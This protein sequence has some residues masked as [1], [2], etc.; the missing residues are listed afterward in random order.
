MEETFG[1]EDSAKSKYKGV[2]KRG[3]TW[4]AGAVGQKGRRVFLGRFTD[5]VMAA[6]AVDYFSAR[7]RPGKKLNQHVHGE[8]QRLF[9]RLEREGRIQELEPS[10]GLVAAKELRGDEGPPLKAPGK[11]GRPPKARKEDDEGVKRVGDNAD[12]LEPLIEEE[13]GVDLERASN[14]RL[15]C[16]S[17]YNVVVDGF[18]FGHYRHLSTAALAEDIVS[19]CM[20]CERRNALAFGDALSRHF[21]RLERAGLLDSFLREV[22]R[23]FQ[24]FTMLL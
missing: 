14:V 21:H 23:R 15:L 19:A 5:E 9:H 2:S 18:S 17:S 11:P 3:D 12:Q 6:A 7:V 10:P 1:E 24:Q 4:E 20:G 8:V 13:E 22:A 16:G